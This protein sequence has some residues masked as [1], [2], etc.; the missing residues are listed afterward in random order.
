MNAEY[1]ATEESTLA[2]ISDYQIDLT[3]RDKQDFKLIERHKATLRSV[4]ATR[5]K[6]E[7]DTP[8]GRIIEEE[9]GAVAIWHRVRAG[10]EDT[11]R[12]LPSKSREA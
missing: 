4:P 6:S 2:G 9:I 3:S 10:L 1:N 12:G 5:F 7:Y 11:S 8:K